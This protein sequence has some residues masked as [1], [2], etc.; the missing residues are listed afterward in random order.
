MKD[1]EKYIFEHNLAAKSIIKQKDKLTKIVNLL[2]DCIINKKKILVAGN[3]GSNAD[4]AHFVTELNCTFYN[5]KRRAISAIDL[6]S[7]PSSI[8]AWSNDFSF[9]TFF[10]RQVQAHGLKNDVLFLISTGGGNIKNKSSMNLFEAAKFAKKKRI[11]IIS[12]LGRDG[13]VL[14][15]I[16]DQFI[17]VESHITSYIQEV[18]KII[19]HIICKSLDEEL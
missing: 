12:L 2:I 14:K 5:K 1:I 8:T 15:N 19:M 7:N 4:S 10:L 11:K 17:L 13:G 9:L 3:G 18:H 16:S 6:A